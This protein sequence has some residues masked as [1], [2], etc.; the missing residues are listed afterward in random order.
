MSDCSLAELIKQ[1][2]YALTP[3][4]MQK[5]GAMLRTPIA[6]DR[7]WDYYVVRAGFRGHE[8]LLTSRGSQRAR[9]NSPR[10]AGFRGM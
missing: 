6:A 5:T 1:P 2:L 4:E 10:R 8:S 7:A 9:R 3:A